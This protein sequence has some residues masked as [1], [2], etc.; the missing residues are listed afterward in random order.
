MMWQSQAP[1]RGQ[2]VWAGIF[3]VGVALG[4]WAL[5]SAYVVD[6]A[7]LPPPS[8]VWRTAV[9]M[10]ISGQLVDAIGISLA[11]VAIGYLIGASA[12]VI[13]GLLLGGVRVVDAVV[14]PVFEFLKGLP[15]IALVP[16]AIM[17]LGIGEASKYVIIAYVVWIVVTISTAAGV[18]EIPV[19]RL[20][21]GQCLGLGAP[22]RFVRIVLPSIV[23]YVMVGMRTAIGFAYVALVSA[24][25]IAANA[26]V[27]YIIMDSRFS[28]QTANM[29][30][31]LVVLGLLGAT[32]QLLFDVAV[33]RCRTLSHS[34]RH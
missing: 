28:L 31:G 1:A 25:L 26:G 33:G 5:T 34:W 9:K 27:G 3:S 12:G 14:G 13:T 29:I 23:S 18:H 7:L 24:E 11:R 32:S 10:V 16:L 19:I 21:A 20:R 15:P 22:A 17:W 30:V 4:A 6:P 8:E 2:A